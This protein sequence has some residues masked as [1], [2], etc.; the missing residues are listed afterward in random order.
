[1]TPLERA[2]DAAWTE[3]ERQYEEGKPGPYVDRENAVIDGNVDMPAVIRTIVSSLRQPTPVM[4]AATRDFSD[5]VHGS[6]I[7]TRDW[8]AMIDA[9]LA[10]TE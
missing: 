7:A 2:L 6:E 10:E 1:M 4:V 5:D 3:L 9:L 8:Q